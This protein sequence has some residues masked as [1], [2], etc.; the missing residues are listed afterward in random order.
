MWL[1]DRW[2]AVSPESVRDDEYH[3]GEV[4]PGYSDWSVDRFIIEVFLWLDGWCQG[5]I[6]TVFF[7]TVPSWQTTRLLPPHQ[8][9]SCHSGGRQQTSHWGHNNRIDAIDI[10]RDFFIFFNNL[11]NTQIFYTLLHAY[12]AV[13]A[14]GWRIVPNVIPLSRLA[15]LICVKQNISPEDRDL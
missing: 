13:F 11:Y 3:Q 10:T 1:T 14:I 15:G 6:V 7:W 9:L 5:V 4:A 8:L 12:L 2:D